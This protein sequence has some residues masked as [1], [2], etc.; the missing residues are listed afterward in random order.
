MSDSDQAL[1]TAIAEN[2][3]LLRERIRLLL[4]WRIAARNGLIAGFCGAVGATLLVSIAIAIIKPLEKIDALK[5]ALEKI[6]Q[7]LNARDRK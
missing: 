1:A 5:P 2:N 3:A 4:D 6:G 7:G